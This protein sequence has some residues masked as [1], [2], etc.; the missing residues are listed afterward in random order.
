MS[1][2]SRALLQR[3]RDELFTV[4][5]RTPTKEE[6]L[7]CPNPLSIRWSAQT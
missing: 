4:R 3:S 6:K 1:D 7:S 2:E 5:V